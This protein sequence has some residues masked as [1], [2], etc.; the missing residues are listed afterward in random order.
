MTL[1]IANDLGFFGSLKLLTEWHISDN[2]FNKVYVTILEINILDYVS[3]PISYF[4]EAE[5][6]QK[7]VLEK[8]NS[9]AVAFKL[10]FWYIEDLLSINNWYFHAYVDSINPSELEI[11]ATESVSSITYSDILPK[12][13]K[14]APF[15]NLI[16]LYYWL[17]VYINHIV[18]N[19]LNIFLVQIRKLLHIKQYQ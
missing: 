9:L 14:Y 16:V 12:M 6:L 19:L 2:N 11:K 13:T 18:F 3:R 1:W 8:K 15:L 5:F 4:H 17:D 7:L 10:T